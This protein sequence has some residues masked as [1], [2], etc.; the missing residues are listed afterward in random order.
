MSGYMGVSKMFGYE[1]GYVLKVRICG[2][3]LLFG[4]VGVHLV[5]VRIYGGTP[6]GCSDM[7]GAPTVETHS[8]ART[9]ARADETTPLPHVFVPTT[10][11]LASARS[12]S[13]CM[14]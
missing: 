5:N 3:L 10:A 1:G 14:L 12:N 13:S 2:V 8:T 7:R 9:D 6:Q 4:Y 11:K